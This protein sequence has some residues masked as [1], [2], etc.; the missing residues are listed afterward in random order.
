MNNLFNTQL[1]EKKNNFN[2]YIKGVEIKK[3]SKYNIQFITQKQHLFF[4]SL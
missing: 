4:T 3:K 1:F 2:F